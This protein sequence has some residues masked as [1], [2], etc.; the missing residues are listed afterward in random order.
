MMTSPLGLVPRDL[1]DVWPAANYDVPVTGD[2]SSDELGRV[3]RMLRSLVE[4]TGY[5]RII[6][7]TDMDLGF[8]NIDVVNTREGQGA[9]HFDALERLK[10]A[11]KKAVADHELRNQKNNQRLKQHF[12]SIARKTTGTDRWVERLSVRGKLPRW[13]LELD[14]T[15]MAVWSI[16]RNGFSFSR[17]AID[18]LHEHDAL[19]AIHLKPDVA[20]RGDVFAQMVLAYEPSIRMGDDVRVLQNGEVVGLA[21]AVAYGWEWGG[22]PGTLAKSHQRKK[23]R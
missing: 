20:W 13:R 6:N 2:W 5:Q 9:T 3:K 21:R 10:Q 11:V 22:T 8:L 1:E 12:M 19:P 4:R 23:N 15:Q 7:H 18:W 17:A 16:D 14:G